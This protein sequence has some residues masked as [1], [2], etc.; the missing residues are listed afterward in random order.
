[1]QAF[2]LIFLIYYILGRYFN[3]FYDANN[4]VFGDVILNWVVISIPFLIAYAIDK[5]SVAIA[6]KAAALSGNAKVETSKDES[7]EI[8]ELKERL[9][10]LEK[11]HNSMYSFVADVMKSN[12]KE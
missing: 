6:I 12:K 11:S 1:M 10:K 3:I 5:L 9:A 8:E 7:N 2:I 4:S